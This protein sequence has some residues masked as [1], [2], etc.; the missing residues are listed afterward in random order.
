MES[1]LAAM[2]E[3]MNQW[4]ASKPQALDFAKEWRPAP[5]Q[6]IIFHFASNGDDGNRFIMPYR[7]HVIDTLSKNNKRFT[8][9]KY[10]PVANGDSDPQCS[11][12]EVGHNDIKERMSIW[13][14]VSYLLHATLPAEKQF[15]VV[16]WNGTNYFMEEVNDFKIWHTSAWK[17]SPWID[18][19][20]HYSMY[21]G[22]HNFQAQIS[23]VGENLARRYKLFALPNSQAFPAEL[24]EQAKTELE[25][26]P[27]MLI[28]D[29]ATA[30]QVAPPQTGASANA[31]ALVISPFQPAQSPVS[32]APWTPVTTAPAPVAMVQPTIESDTAP[33]PPAV[34]QEEDQR[35][36]LT[37]LF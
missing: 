35:R 10:C 23:V 26:I 30:V 6:I 5:K 2:N 19:N 31:P 16:G 8:T 12:C 37:K 33:N 17:E 13:M 3:R 18:I 29:L 27:E 32:V 11:Y 1:S 9:H 21:K 20:T 15:P 24:Y 14:Y 34:T 36:P 25:P 4:M 28:K 7:A 22:L